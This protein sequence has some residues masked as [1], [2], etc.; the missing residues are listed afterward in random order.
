MRA[1]CIFSPR[2]P[3]RRYPS[4]W[5]CSW[6]T[7]II[8]NGIYKSTNKLTTVR[9]S[10]LVFC[11]FLGLVFK[12]QIC[13]IIKKKKIR[14]DLHKSSLF[15]LMILSIKLIFQCIPSECCF[16]NLNQKVYFKNLILFSNLSDISTANSE[17]L[18]SSS[19]VLCKHILSSFLTHSFADEFELNV[20]ALWIEYI[21]IWAQMK[22]PFIKL[23]CQSEMDYIWSG[24]C[25]LTSLCWRTH[26]H[27]IYMAHFLFTLKIYM[28][29]FK[30]S[31]Y[32]T[33]ILV[34]LAQ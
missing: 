33:A 12:M 31:S 14:W 26:K 7:D 10:K 29:K 3:W 17:S 6:E 8:N 4:Q 19:Y 13:I 21:Q 34:Y 32:L 16:G 25:K 22:N 28:W 2:M 20:P 18:P 1:L 11:C 30:I 27:D 24:S 23:R 9:K 5:S 15:F